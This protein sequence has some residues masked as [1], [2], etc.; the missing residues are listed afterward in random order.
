MITGHGYNMGSII[1]IDFFFFIKA[2][3]HIPVSY[4]H[5]DVYKRQ[6]L[7]LGT[8]E[9]TNFLN[10][11]HN[12]SNKM[13]GNIINDSYIDDDQKLWMAV[14]PIGITVYSEKYPGYQWIQHSYD[15]LLY[16]SIIR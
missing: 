7:K 2:I 14:Y 6:K 13:N 8:Y 3:N 4:T 16:T 10:A 11:D 12:H 15:C 9:L 1:Q 5:L